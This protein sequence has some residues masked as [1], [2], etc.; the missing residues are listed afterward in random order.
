MG[1]ALCEFRDFFKKIPQ[2]S[3]I[4]LFKIDLIRFDA[5]DIS[6]LSKQIRYLF[7]RGKLKLKIKLYVLFAMLDAYYVT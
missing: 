1:T 6:V 3:N 7:E 4:S 2:H 5:S